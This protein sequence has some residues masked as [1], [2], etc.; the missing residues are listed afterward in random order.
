MQG[1][2]SFGHCVLE[3][4]QD[5]MTFWPKNC[6]SVQHQIH[7]RCASFFKVSSIFDVYS[8]LLS[9]FAQII[10]QTFVIKVPLFTNCRNFKCLSRLNRNRENAHLRQLSADAAN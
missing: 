9:Y 2:Y 4:T 1:L 6:K 10:L 3:F 5:L 7:Q 8:H